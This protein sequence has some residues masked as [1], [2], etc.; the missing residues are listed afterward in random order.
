MISAASFNYLGMGH[1]I[2]YFD[3]TLSSAF[4]ND[5]AQWEGLQTP[6]THPEIHL[7]VGII[8]REIWS[9]LIISFSLRFST[10]RGFGMSG[11]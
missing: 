11:S 2:R 3:V 1:F 8:Q 9:R 10:T 7:A 6:K 4:I 5:M